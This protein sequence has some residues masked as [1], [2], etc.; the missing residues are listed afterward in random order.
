[1]LIE[2]PSTLTEIS[3]SVGAAAAAGL[4]FAVIMDIEAEIGGG[5]RSA[6]KTP[7][8]TAPRSA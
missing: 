7:R 4:G 2:D 1:M 6:W 8:R 3:V 5:L